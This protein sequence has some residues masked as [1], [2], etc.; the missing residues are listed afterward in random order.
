MDCD[1]PQELLREVAQTIREQEKVARVRKLN[2]MDEEQLIA[3]TNKRRTT[4]R[5]NLD[6]GSFIQHRTNDMTFLAALQRLDNEVLKNAAYK[7]RRHPVIVVDE[8][9][10]RKRIPNYLPVRDGIFVYRKMTAAEKM[11]FLNYLDELYYLNW[12]VELR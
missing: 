5:V 2:R 11:K 8:T 3:F 4:I 12:I 9:R 1:V 10:R 6:D 7:V